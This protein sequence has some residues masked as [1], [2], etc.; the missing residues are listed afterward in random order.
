MIIVMNVLSLTH[1]RPNDRDHTVIDP[2]T[3]HYHETNNSPAI[4]PALRVGTDVSDQSY[5]VGTITQLDPPTSP[6]CPAH[7][8]DQDWATG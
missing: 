1:M 8:S 6:S 5:A 3:L 2:D 7:T 4:D